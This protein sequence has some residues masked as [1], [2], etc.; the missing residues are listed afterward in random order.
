MDYFSLKKKAIMGAAQSGK[1]TTAE[2]YPLKLEN[3]IKGNMKD[4]KIWGNKKGKNYLDIS[5]IVATPNSTA[6]MFI[7]NVDASTGTIALGFD[8]AT[9]G[10]IYKVINKTLGVL[11]PELEVGKTF[12]LNGISSSDKYLFL[13]KSASYWSF[14]TARTITEDDLNSTI[15]IYGD[16]L[17]ATDE[18]VYKIEGL[19]ITEEASTE[20]EPYQENDGLGAFSGNLFDISKIVATP[21][22]TANVVVTEVD[23]STGSVY[24]NTVEGYTANGY[25]NTLQSLKVFAPYLEVG[26]TYYLNGQSPSSNKFMYLITSK[27]YWNFGKART[28]TED[29]LNSTVILYGLSAK[30]GDGTGI[31]KIEGLSIT[32][33][34]STEYRPYNY[35]DVVSSG[36][37]LANL[38]RDTFVTDGITFTNNGNQTF[39]INGTAETTAGRDNY[40]C[41]PKVSI[42]AY[43]PI[44]TLK[45][46]TTYTLTYEVISGTVTNVP[47]IMNI[48]LWGKRDGK[49]TS[50]LYYRSIKS[51]TSSGK[52]TLKFTPTSEEEVYNIVFYIH[53]NEGITFDNF[54]IRIQLEEGTAETPYE[55]FRE[56]T[57][58]TIDLT[59]HNSIMPN[60]YLDFRNGCIVRNDGTEEDIILPKIPTFKGYNI[61]AAS[62]AELE[63]TNMYGKYLKKG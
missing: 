6:S 12:Y 49:A 39:T 8:T 45:A 1:L 38:K 58:T 34:A 22:S 54:T 2:G 36:K 18:G 42:S 3:A 32:E 37:N 20:Y 19:S 17:R 56:P 55:P 16:T 62:D 60:E 50:N 14:G 57:T 43:E 47:S 51:L 30:V 63:T 44:C 9:S 15:I 13:L 52:L 5:K 29:D 26:K 4:Y 48:S 31:C 10:T 61:L 21:D 40:L 33:E 11:A 24:I 23:T 27:D 46:N 25:C 28:I 7:A 41:Y 35:I 59:G 53:E